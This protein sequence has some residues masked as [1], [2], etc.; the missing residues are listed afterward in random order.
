M[1]YKVFFAK[2]PG[3]QS[4]RRCR[5]K[6][7]KEKKK[8]KGFIAPEWIFTAGEDTFFVNDPFDYYRGFMAR[9]K[10]MDVQHRHVDPTGA[11]S[12]PN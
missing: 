9:L 4:R 11:V 7:K 8:K 12:T 5:R 10:S 6:K 2:I 1:A 3:K